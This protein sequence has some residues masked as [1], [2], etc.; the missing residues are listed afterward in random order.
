MCGLIDED[1]D[2]NDSRSRAVVPVPRPSLQSP[3]NSLEIKGSEVA[4]RQNDHKQ[5]CYSARCLLRSD[6]ISASK[7]IGVQGADYV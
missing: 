4:G 2:Q 7:C 5:T 1:S 6:S 3:K